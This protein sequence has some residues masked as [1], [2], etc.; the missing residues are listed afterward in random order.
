MRADAQRLRHCRR[1]AGMRRDQ[2]PGIGGIARAA[3][4]KESA[5]GEAAAALRRLRRRAAMVSTT[6]AS[7]IPASSFCR[8][9]MSAV[10]APPFYAVS[11]C[12]DRV[13]VVAI[14]PAERRPRAPGAP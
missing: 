12:I 13:F 6:E 9:R 5:R 11:F 2:D 1:R 7:P 14:L 10:S 4:P 3:S 8:P